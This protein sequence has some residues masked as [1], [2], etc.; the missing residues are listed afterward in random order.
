MFL[1][2]LQA[3][4][5]CLDTGL[6]LEAYFASEDGMRL[7][8]AMKGEVIFTAFMYEPDEVS[9]KFKKLTEKYEIKR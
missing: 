2:S 7:S 3:G 4:V 6:P 8:T 9:R 1:F 5:M